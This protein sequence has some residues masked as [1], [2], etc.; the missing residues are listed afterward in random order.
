MIAPITGKLRK[1]FWLDVG[2]ALGLGISGGYAYWYG[3]HL[4]H[5]ERQENFYLQLEKQ[6]AKANEA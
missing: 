1:R 5:I 3:V 6:K 2:C 4:K